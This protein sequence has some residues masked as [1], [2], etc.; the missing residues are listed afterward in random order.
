MYETVD[1]CACGSMLAPHSLA[2]PSPHLAFLSPDAS[3]AGLLASLTGT[4]TP[5]C[6]KKK[7]KNQFIT[8]MDI[9]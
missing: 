7:K 4:K 6:F 9:S 5:R 8:E 3:Q 1:I 2:L